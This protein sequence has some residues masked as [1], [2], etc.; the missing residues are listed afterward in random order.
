MTRMK[1][2]AALA[3]ISV[4]LYCLWAWA[5]DPQGRL[6]LGRFGAEGLA[7]WE[8][9]AFEG[10]TSYSLSTDSEGRASLKAQTDGGASGL[11][12]EA[13]I[14]LTQTPFLNW[15]WKVEKVFEGLSE[16]TRRGDDYPARVYVVFSGGL[17]FWQTRAL[18]Y[19]WASTSRKGASWPNAYT[20]NARMV[21]VRSVED[22]LGVWYSEKRNI[23][24]DY[25]RFFGEDVREAHAVAIMTDADQSGQK[26]VA[27]YG[28]IYLSKE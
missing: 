15:S 27:W 13:K 3:I 1:I 20:A 18:N 22:P 7:G 9:K 26:A 10:S 5:E 12:K 8:E 21:A 28:D 17:F 23:R 11:F 24:E 6:F 19:V 14:D 25:R 4:A 16:E 2:A